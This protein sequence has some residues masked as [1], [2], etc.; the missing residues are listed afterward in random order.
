MVLRLTLQ[1]GSCWTLNFIISH[2]LLPTNCMYY[3]NTVLNTKFKGLVCID[4]RDPHL[5]LLPCPLCLPLCG[6][7]LHY[8]LTKSKRLSPC[9]PSWWSWLGACW[10]LSLRHLPVG[11]EKMQSRPL[12]TK[13]CASC[14]P[15]LQPVM[16]WS[17]WNHAHTA[18]MLWAMGGRHG[19]QA[20]AWSMQTPSDRLPCSRW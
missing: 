10:W 2:V 6:E 8:A 11:A 5:S 4:N 12:I 19:A 7:F 13:T 17:S 1:F 14:L 20:F 18:W 16:N 15:F 9:H 3:L